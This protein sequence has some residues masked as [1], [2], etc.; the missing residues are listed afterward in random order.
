MLSVS[1]TNVQQLHILEEVY[2][3][4]PKILK[5]FKW[6]LKYLIY[7]EYLSALIKYFFLVI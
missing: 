5:V 3:Y 2:I 6:Y 4:I 1:S 7:I